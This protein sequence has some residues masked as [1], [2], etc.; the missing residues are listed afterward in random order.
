MVEG[1]CLH[2]GVALC[3]TDLLMSAEP[4]HSCNRTP[5]VAFG[6]SSLSE[7][8]ICNSW[9]SQFMIFDRKSIH[10]A[11]REIIFLTFVKKKHIIQTNPV[12]G[13]KQRQENAK[14]SRGLR[15][16][17]FATKVFVIHHP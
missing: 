10:G 7:G 16:K 11:K 8:A 3:A 12:I 14:E 5:S 4:T 17:P 1:V 6:D 2:E 15:L 13:T 9:R